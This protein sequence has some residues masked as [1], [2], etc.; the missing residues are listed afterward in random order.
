MIDFKEYIHDL[1]TKSIEE[2]KPY[3]E[4][5]N[6]KLGLEVG[7]GD[8]F[9]SR[10]LVNYLEKLVVTE[11]S[12]ERLEQIPNEKIKYYICDAEKL[13]D[14]LAFSSFDIIF[15][16]HLLEH[17]P[18]AERF[19]VSCNKLIAEDGAIIHVVP[20]NW[21]AFFRLLFWYP[22]ILVRFKRKLA[23]KKSFN[24]LSKP[25]SITNNNLKTSYKPRIKL[26]EYLFPRAHGVSENVFKEYLSMRKKSWTKLFTENGLKVERIMKGSC[27]SGYGFGFEKS[28][29]LLSRIGMA[30][31]YIYI[32]KRSKND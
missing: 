4:R 22:A 18:H 27:F 16:S 15:S 25:E 31:E 7:A 12:Q 32:L 17:L 14:Q 21:Y 30:C 5:S 3:I 29:R 10:L 19:I 28:K 24:L 23:R 20:S 26:F 6:V 13:E 8:G 1:R 9:Q 11:Y 2:I